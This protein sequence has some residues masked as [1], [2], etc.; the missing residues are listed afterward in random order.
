MLC[1][2]CAVAVLICFALEFLRTLRATLESSSAARKVHQLFLDDAQNLHLHSCYPSQYLFRMLFRALRNA[3]G[4][5]RQNAAFLSGIQVRE[6]NFDFL[7]DVEKI[8][9][10]LGL[11][12][13]NA[14]DLDDL[15]LERAD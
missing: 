6:I 1:A 2:S 3:V 15:A 13:V 11:S 9:E 8:H 10:H 4:E 12:S 5:L 14:F 7:A